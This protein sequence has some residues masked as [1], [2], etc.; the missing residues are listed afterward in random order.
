MDPVDLVVS[1][2]AARATVALKETVS[3]AAKDVYAKLKTLIHWSK[4][5]E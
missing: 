1:A 4:S 5:R 2:L 3:Q